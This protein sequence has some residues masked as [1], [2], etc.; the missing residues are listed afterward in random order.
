M[1]ESD[2]RPGRN[3][4][5]G[6]GY[7]KPPAKG[8]DWDV[9]DDNVPDVLDDPKKRR[10]LLRKYGY[11]ENDLK[12]SAKRQLFY[13]AVRQNLSR[14]DARQQ[15]K[16]VYVNDQASVAEIISKSGFT[17]ELIRRFP[18]LR[19]VFARLSDLLARGV[20][21]ESPDALFNKFKEL[22]DDTAFGKRAT[23]EVRAD[24]YR[25]RSDTD[26][27]FQQTFGSLIERINEVATGMRGPVSAAVARK[28]ALDLMYADSGFLMGNF[29]ESEITRRLRPILFPTGGGDTGG[30]G[31]DSSGGSGGDTGGGGTTDGGTD[32]GDDAGTGNLGGTAGKWQDEL[33]SWFAANGIT[34]SQSAIDRHLA[35]LSNGYKTIDQIKQD[36]RD[37]YL[38]RH[39]AGYADLFKGGMDLS[40]IALDFRTR[41]ANIL[42][43]SVDSIGLDN[44]LVQRALNYRDDKNNPAPMTFYD[45]D[46]LVRQDPNWD[47]TDS[48]MSM[49]TNIGESILSS[50]G[51]RG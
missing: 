1:A 11:T 43:M 14:A 12:F 2:K 44:D 40:D 46:R 41:A 5:S 22:V 48:A 17:L 37:G 51:F 15:Y 9:N 35:D 18:E 29:D 7:G 49:Y 19:N 10:A 4:A 26:Q 3:S 38:T 25:Y 16:D 50:F 13:K 31:T 34:V 47:K 39:Y 23:S 27:D 42:E 36:Y 33:V 45:F 21:T 30:G 8:P 32:N 6:S 20:I 28:M 24:F